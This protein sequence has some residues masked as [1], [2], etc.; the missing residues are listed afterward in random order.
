MLL[1]EG[2]DR[3]ASGRRSFAKSAKRSL[4]LPNGIASVVFPGII[5][6]SMSTLALLVVL[7]VP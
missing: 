7:A 4:P 5:V 1:V 2:L 3:E 6:T